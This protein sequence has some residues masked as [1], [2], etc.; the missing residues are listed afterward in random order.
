MAGRAAGELELVFWVDGTSVEN[1]QQE[2]VVEAPQ[3]NGKEL[4]KPEAEICWHLTAQ[5]P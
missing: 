3:G 4:E 2:L 5:G 1:S